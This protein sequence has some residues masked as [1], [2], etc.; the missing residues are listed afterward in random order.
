MG[1]GLHNGPNKNLS[2]SPANVGR[3]L[4]LH[5]EGRGAS[6]RLAHAG[7]SVPAWTRSVAELWQ[8]QAW[9][10]SGPGSA[11]YKCARPAQT[12]W[13]PLDAGRPG[14]HLLRTG[15]GWILSHLAPRG[16]GRDERLGLVSGARSHVGSCNCRDQHRPWPAWLLLLLAGTVSTTR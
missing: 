5:T 14:T 12:V 11:Q 15:P 1:H 3:W 7:S 10:A 9:P 6:T 13:M 4:V 16:P 8:A 2:P